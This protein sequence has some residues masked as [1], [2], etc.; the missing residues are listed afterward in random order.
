MPSPFFSASKALNVFCEF[1][2]KKEKRSKNGVTRANVKLCQSSGSVNRHAVIYLLP[3]RHGGD[4]PQDF[5][6]Q[7]FL[8]TFP[9]FVAGYTVARRFNLSLS[10][11]KAAEFSTLR[12]TVASFTE[13]SM[14]DA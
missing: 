13:K 14:R 4:T 9:G 7:L 11:V 3:T 5:I 2:K 8:S 1:P 6:A 10:A 12:S